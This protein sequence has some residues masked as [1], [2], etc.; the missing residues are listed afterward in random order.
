MGGG[1]YVELGERGV[2]A[3]SGPDARAFLQGLVSND[4]LRV[5]PAREAERP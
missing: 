3:V 2:V 1:S 4:V 5:S